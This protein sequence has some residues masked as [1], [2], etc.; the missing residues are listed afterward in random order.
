MTPAGTGWRIFAVASALNLAW[1]ITQSFA[2]G[3]TAWKSFRTLAM[4]SAA[5]IGDGVFALALYWAGVIISGDPKWVFRMTAG[6][7]S[8]ILAV[9][10][11][12][13]VI[14]ERAALSGSLWQYAGSMP[15][16]PV[17]GAG[18]WPVLQLMIL[19][20]AAFYI[21]RFTRAGWVS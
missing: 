16:I 13:A 9:G 10:L 19:P 14:M 2:Y 8:A 18:L 3:G 21:V 11:A 7:L 20:L 15:R 17:I 4:C 5:A 6:R 12:T 1:E